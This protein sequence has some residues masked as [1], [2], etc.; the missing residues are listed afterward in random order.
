MSED[1]EEGNK[2]FTAESLPCQFAYITCFV[3][4]FLGFCWRIRMVENALDHIMDK[5]GDFLIIAYF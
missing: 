4:H 5:V 3:D 2:T 1:V